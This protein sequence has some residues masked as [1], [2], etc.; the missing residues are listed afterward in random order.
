MSTE[1]TP[2]PVLPDLTNDAAR[3]QWLSGGT[4]ISAGKTEESAPSEPAEQAVSTETHDKPASETGDPA[5]SRARKAK[6]AEERVPELLNDRAEERRLRME[7]QARADDLERRL[8]ALESPTKDGKTA[9]SSPA[10]DKKAEAARFRAMPDAPK[11]E[12]FESYDDWAIEMASFV[13]DKKLEERE[14][15]SQQEAAARQEEQRFTE[16][17]TKASERFKGYLEK[18]PEAKDRIRPELMAIVPISQ[19]RPGE[20]PGPHNFIAEQILES[21]FSGELADHFSTDAGV[22]DFQRFMRLSPDAILREIGRLEARFEDRG[23]TAPTRTP[24]TISTAPDPPETFGR[25]PAAPADRLEAALA[26]GDFNAYAEE[27]NRRDWA[28]NNP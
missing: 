4:A 2:A 8:R 6:S 16:K 11:L 13:A 18:H 28:R 3:E 10:V 22:Q 14:A 9:E 15:R 27:A 7:A 12:E 24:K 25:R 5:S 1:M 17:V 20:T 23:K 19:L 21:E 26:T